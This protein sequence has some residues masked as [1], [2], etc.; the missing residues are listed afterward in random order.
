MDSIPTLFEEL[1][2]YISKSSFKK[3]IRVCNKILG[4]EAGNVQAFQCKVIC[5]MQLSNFQE[6]IDCFKKSKQIE[7]MSFEYSYCLYALN[8][9]QESLKQLEKSQKDNRSLELE[10]QIHYK[11]ED[12]SKTIS[13]YESLLS[14]P[15]YSDSV[16]FITNLCAVY[17]EAGKLNECQ[18]LINKN[19]GQQT[20]TYELAFNSACLAIA[21]KDIKTAETQLKLAKKVCTDSLK[22]DGFSEEEI[23]EE[24]TSIDTQLAYCQQI[25]GNFEKSLELYQSVLDQEVGD[26]PSLI[27]ANNKTSI[28]INSSKTH[29]TKELT[30]ALET[31]RSLLSESNESRLNG[32][33]KRVFNYNICLLLLQLKKIGQCEELI[34]SIKNKFKGAQNSSLED[35]DIINSTLLI[36]EKK[37]GEVEKLL[38]GHSASSL[39]SQL[40]L[41]QVYLLDN[42]VVKALG[43]LE[44]LDETVSN[45][46]GIIATKCALYEKSGNLD[47]AIACL[48]TLISQLESKSKRTEQEDES[49]V[50]LLKACGNFKLKHHKYKEA[51]EMFDRVLKINPNDLLALPSYIVATSHFDAS[52]SQKYQGKLP[53]IKFE[54]K[55]DLDSVEKYGL[56][57]EKK[58]NE[59]SDASASAVVEK[60]SNKAPIKLGDGTLVEIK[61]S[62]NKLPKN[63]VA[64]YTPDPDRWLPKW[65]RAN[66]KASRKKNAK[67]VVKGPQ[68]LASA[69][70]TASLFVKESTKAQPAQPSQSSSKSDKPKNLHKKKSKK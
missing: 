11:L 40:L 65:Q 8:K 13:I 56:A 39:K 54:S 15:E 14:K 31:L 47:K 51:A 35:L 69:S 46:P 52:L 70:Q 30:T 34:K 9:Y 12:Y 6:A 18:D 60:K 68:G 19:K 1:D 67:D 17:L 42:N 50:G 33:Q 64:N 28:S 23:K 59:S 27:A 4:I 53:N 16:E 26:G 7:S 58:T 2:E 66:A 37:Y 62:K 21:K 38:K 55:I 41:A 43:V 36:R 63:I 29:E 32:K 3:A 45:K 61:K 49:Y 24:Q 20:K 48:D 5:L 25:N 44:Q 10:A 22:Q 57:Y